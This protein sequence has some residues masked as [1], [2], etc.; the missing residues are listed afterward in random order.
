MVKHLAIAI[1]FVSACAAQSGSVQIV[2]LA[3]SQ[4]PGPWLVM[5]NVLAGCGLDLGITEN[6]RA[7]ITFDDRGWP[8]SVASAYGDEFAKCVGN[9]IERTRYREQRDRTL[10]IQLSAPLDAQTSNTVPPPSACSPCETAAAACAQCEQT[11]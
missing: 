2:A 4:P 10:V 7:R 8:L 5:R 6:V 9:G 3:P 11:R 1:V